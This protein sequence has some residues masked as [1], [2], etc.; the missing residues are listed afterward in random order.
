[1]L[2]AREDTGALH[3]IPTAYFDK[4]M[5]IFCCHITSN[6]STNC[7]D[8]TA[9]ATPNLVETF[10][11]ENYEISQSGQKWQAPSLW[12]DPKATKGLN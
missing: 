7:T 11:G 3:L 12:A 9:A 10:Q 1:M 5:F 6:I 2:P 4:V 8:F